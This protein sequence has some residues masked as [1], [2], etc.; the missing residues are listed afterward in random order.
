M[1]LDYVCASRVKF[2][3]HQT[4]SQEVTS[5]LN[6]DKSLQHFLS[7]LNAEE[8]HDKTIEIV[9]VQNNKIKLT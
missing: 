9:L 5:H 6:P 3:F 8:H 7:L 1:K 2:L 4:F